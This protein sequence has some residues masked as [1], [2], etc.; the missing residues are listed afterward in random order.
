LIIAAGSLL[1]LL[2]GC[3][4][5]LSYLS[6][7]DSVEAARA[8]NADVLA[9]YE[10]Q[11]AATY[12]DAAKRELEESDYASARKFS[13]IASQRAHAGETAAKEKQSRPMISYTDG[14]KLRG[15][16]A[17]PPPAPVAVVPAPAPAPT[18]V[19]A[20]APAPAVA[21]A[22]AAAPTPAPA[23]AT[24]PPAAPVTPAT[25]QAPAAPAPA[26]PAPVAPAPVAPA[27]APVAPPPAAQPAPT[28]PPPAVAPAP[29]PEVDKDAIDKRIR[30]LLE[31]DEDDDDDTGGD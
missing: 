10:Y 2:S 20:P 25:T 4:A 31:E 30:K 14:L 17:T 15:I 21:P 23:I 11:S 29:E 19:P 13:G 5:H 9:P 26:T 24:P 12:L 22:P 8:A 3:A 16:A 28:P 18:P 6:A 1:V 27:P 7:K